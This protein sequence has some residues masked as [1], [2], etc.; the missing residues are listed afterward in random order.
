MY[1]LTTLFSLFSTNKTCNLI[2]IQAVTFFVWLMQSHPGQCQHC[3]EIY[4]FKGTM[5]ELKMAYIGKFKLYLLGRPWTLESL[6]YNL[7]VQSLSGIHV[8]IMLKYELTARVR[9]WVCIHFGHPRG[10]ISYWQRE[11]V[12]QTVLL[13]SESGFSQS[14]LACHLIGSPQQCK[15]VKFLFWL[16]ISFNAMLYTNTNTDMF[17]VVIHF[18]LHIPLSRKSNLFFFLFLTY[19]LNWRPT[20]PVHSAVTRSSNFCFIIVNMKYLEI[21]G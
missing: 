15:C 9:D 7:A 12:C 14:K 2:E 18:V 5:K 13:S 3:L 1:S 10:M 11:M 21:H 6:I 19:C 16:C 8:F 20:P 17:W 4:F